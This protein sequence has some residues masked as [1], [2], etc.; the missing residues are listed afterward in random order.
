MLEQLVDGSRERAAPLAP[1]VD[2]LRAHVA[3]MAPARDLEA[4][5]RQPGL[6]VIAEIKRRSPSVGPIAPDLDPRRLGPAYE[7]GGAAAL[8][9]LTDPAGFGAYPADLPQAT[10]AV[11]I[12]VLRKDFIVEP[13]QVWETRA[14]GADAVLLIVAALDA[15]SLEALIAEAR[16][17]GLAHL[18]EAHTADEVTG[19]IDAGA[20]IV[21]VNNRDLST[22]TVDLAVAESLRT[23][24]PDGVV[25]VAESG[26]RSTDDA[27]RMRDAGYDAVLV[28]EAAAGSGD[29]ATFIQSLSEIP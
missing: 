13:A 14:M 25:A 8:S 2:R 16:A 20:D 23:L 12:P 11:G 7:A 15:A 18:V 29:P 27:R 17:A 10:R 1:H 4:A 6:S 24:I 26:V 3:S 5:L 21:G 22:F 9:V 28:G 19:A